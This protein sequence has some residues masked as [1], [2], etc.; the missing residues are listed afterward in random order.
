MMASL[1]ING[2]C[3]LRTQFSFDFYINLNFIVSGFQVFCKRHWHQYCDG[4]THYSGVVLTLRWYFP[5][6]KLENKFSIVYMLS[7]WCSNLKFQSTSFTQGMSSTFL[8]RPGEAAI[9]FTHPLYMRSAWLSTR[10]LQKVPYGPR[11]W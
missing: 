6:N 8:M 4:R 3:I 11:C 1:P 9:L 2:L 7:T 5:K 10:Y